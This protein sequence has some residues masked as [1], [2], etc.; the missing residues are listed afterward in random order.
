VNSGSPGYNA[1]VHREKVA[2]TLGDRRY[3]Q[4]WQ[5]FQRLD[6]KATTLEFH[7]EGDA[8]PIPIGA[9]GAIS[10]STI[11]APEPF[12]CPQQARGCDP[13]ANFLTKDAFWKKV[14]AEERVELEFSAEVSGEP[15]PLVVLCSVDVSEGMLT[16]MMMNRWY[17]AS[18]WSAY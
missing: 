5:S 3:E 13:D 9:G 12:R 8:S 6:R 14:G 10:H 15:R 2:F 11:F 16:I 4:T 1:I 7:R 18:C 17:S